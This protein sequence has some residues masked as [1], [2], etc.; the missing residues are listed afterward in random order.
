MKSEPMVRSC[1]EKYDKKRELHCESS[2][3]P[4]LF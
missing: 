1:A 3:I 4:V 2:I